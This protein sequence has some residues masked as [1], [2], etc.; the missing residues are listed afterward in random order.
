MV[1]DW[2]YDDFK[3]RNDNFFAW[4]NVRVVLEVAQKDR[5]ER[6]EIRAQTLGPKEELDL[7][8]FRVKEGQGPVECRVEV[9]AN[10]GKMLVEKLL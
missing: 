2:I 1:P 8:E 7:L 10:E 6:S 5:K 4:S 3:V 9:T